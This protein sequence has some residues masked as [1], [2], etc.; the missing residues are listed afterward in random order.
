MG[1]DRKGGPGLKEF[2]TPADTVALIATPLVVRLPY[3]RT[4]IH[5]GLVHVI[6][7]GKVL[8]VQDQRVD[9]AGRDLFCRSPRRHGERVHPGAQVRSE[10][11]AVFAQLHCSARPTRPGRSGAA[12][13][14]SDAHT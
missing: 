6:A 2:P 10:S 4:Y 8:V 13:S 5:G 1:C 12:T 14:W 7:K 9:M 3:S 11:T